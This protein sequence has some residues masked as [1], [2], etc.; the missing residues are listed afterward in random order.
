MK[1]RKKNRARVYGFTGY[2]VGALLDLIFSKK[3]IQAHVEL[4]NLDDYL[5]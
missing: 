1:G 5:D 3:K 2:Y 4:S